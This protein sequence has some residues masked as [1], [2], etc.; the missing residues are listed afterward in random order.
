M[1]RTIASRP[2]G[3]QSA[4]MMFFSTGKGAPPFIGTRARSAPVMLAVPLDD[5]S[6]S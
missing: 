2:S 3:A 5:S 6:A 4:A 1:A